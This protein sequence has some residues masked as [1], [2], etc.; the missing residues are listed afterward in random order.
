MNLKFKRAISCISYREDVPCGSFE[1][2]CIR[3]LNKIC[4]GFALFHFQFMNI[5]THHN[6]PS[7]LECQKTMLIANIEF[8]KPSDI[9][10]F[11]CMPMNMK[12]KRASHETAVLDK[13]MITNCSLIKI[14]HGIALFT[15]QFM[16]NFKGISSILSSV[17]QIFSPRE[18]N[19]VRHVIKSF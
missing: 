2:V 8:S 19:F 15:F 14:C 17:L 5:G 11:R 12:I 16:R 6:V 3:K 13:W 1:H 7:L 10:T 9:A 18:N 4:H